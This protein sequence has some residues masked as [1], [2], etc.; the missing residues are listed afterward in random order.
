M[1]Q[2]QELLHLLRERPAGITPMEALVE[3]GTM[4]LAARVYDLRAEGHAIEDE[5]V[6]VRARNGRVAHVK[7]YRL[8][9]A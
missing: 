9:A 1:T 6:P 3:I 4:R 8:V 5:T 2:T 7:R